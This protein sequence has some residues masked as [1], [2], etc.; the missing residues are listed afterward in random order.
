MSAH[1]FAFR[2]IDGAPLP[3]SSFAGKA[4]L[5]VNTASA[6]GLTPQY[7]GLEAL[8]RDYRDRGLVVL[9]V[10]CNDFGA[11]EPGTEAEIKTFCETRFA[12]DFPMASKEK[13]IG[14]GAH[15]FYRWVVGQLGEDAAP[16]WNF[17]KYLIAPDGSLAGTFG[18]RTAPQA[19]EIKQAIEDVLPG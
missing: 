12:V 1:D 8:W 13:V 2:T 15:P 11:Q 9:G 16:K 19:A 6:C 5:V 10:P 7:D 3:L 18:S 14:G 4:V 17:H